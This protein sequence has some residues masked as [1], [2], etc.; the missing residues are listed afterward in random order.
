MPPR[1]CRGKRKSTLSHKRHRRLVR[2]TWLTNCSLVMPL[3]GLSTPLGGV[4]THD[5]QA[6]DTIPF[7]IPSNYQ[8]TPLPSPSPSSFHAVKPSEVIADAIRDPHVSRQ[9]LGLG[10][11]RELYCT[12]YGSAVWQCYTV[13]TVGKEKRCYKVLTAYLVISADKFSI[14]RNRKSLYGAWR[15]L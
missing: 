3:F 10:E 2:M 11:V 6:R 4:L 1:G 5:N 12:E 9:L 8:H 13:R 14:T 7:P 15:S